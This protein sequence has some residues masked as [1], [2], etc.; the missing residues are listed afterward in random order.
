MSNESCVV[1][2][3]AGAI[4]DVRTAH[5]LNTNGTLATSGTV[6]AAIDNLT[7]TPAGDGDNVTVTVSFTFS[8]LNSAGT[9]VRSSIDLRATGVDG[10]APQYVRFSLGRLIPGGT[11]SFTGTTWPLPN[12]WNAYILRPTLTG[13]SPYYVETGTISGTP[14]TGVYTYT[15][16]AGAVRGYVEGVN[17]NQVH[18]VAIQVR[19]PPLSAFFVNGLDPTLEAPVGNDT[20]DWVPLLAAVPTT[21]YPTRN[22]VTT[23]A[24]NQCH[25]PL[26]IHGG[27]RRETAFCVVCH[28]P[29]IG[30]FTGWD[31]GTLVKLVHGIH[32]EKNLGPIVPGEAD[33]DKSLITYPQSVKNC[34]TCHQGTDG[35][36]W[37]VVPSREAC[38]NCHTTVINFATGAGHNTNGAP[39]AQA[40]DTRCGFCHT[41][42]AIIAFHADNTATPTNVPAALDNITYDLSSVTMN[43]SRQPVVVF[44]I[45]KNGTPVTLNSFTGTTDAEKR[46]FVVGTASTSSLL[47]G[48]TGSPSFLVAFAT[49]QDGV[50]TPADYN[51]QG[52]T[53]TGTG[54]AG[55]TFGQPA[56]VSIAELR[57]GDGGSMTGP[58]ASG[59][60]TATLAAQVTRSSAAATI[61][62][63]TA[64]Y[65]AAYPAGATMK[66]VGM[67]GYFIQALQRRPTTSRV[68]A[69]TGE[70]FVR[71]T[72]VD[73][74]KCLA[75]HKQLALHGN[76]RVNNV[77]LCVM[78]HN[79]SNVQAG[80]VWDMKEMV[81]GI[82]AAAFRGPDET[83]TTDFAGVTYP[84]NLRHCTKCH[85]GTSLATS[86]YTASLPDNVLLTTVAGTGFAATDN[87]N[88]PTASACYYCHASST[89]ASHFVQM[90]G[91]IMS[92]R[93][94]A[95]LALP[96][97]VIVT[98]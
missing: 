7:F 76:N 78:C 3:G 85:I 47:T 15:F 17:D 1:C 18:R 42:T 97:D 81:H 87:V 29:T 6:S 20:F 33:F 40:D 37:N 43:A 90:G 41:P 56:T 66:A 54:A 10:S 35:A 98:P 28:N 9:Q 25:D 21:A 34:D 11:A 62:A 94:G 2:H 46:D 12:E 24:C 36:N 96:W 8:A 19:N 32:S 53:G 63:I 30:T 51:N 77:Q 27:G 74:A 16:P 67:Q 84:A 83:Y 61:G 4:E 65:N 60:Y 48:F 39:G 45:N 52:V 72:V 14:A 82:H 22:I 49:A 57:T 5:T 26:A 93:T 75:C 31:N 73:N 79:T 88:S 69:V 89:A 55:K 71:R 23:A 95:L 68:Q 92:T 50:S 86:T 58:D 80:G 13:S 59:F 44:R 91:D 64:T 38:G 70:T